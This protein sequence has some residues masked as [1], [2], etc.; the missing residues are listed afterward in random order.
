LS[1]FYGSITY[2]EILIFIY[3]HPVTIYYFNSTLVSLVLGFVFGDLMLPTRSVAL[4]LVALIMICTNVSAQSPRPTAAGVNFTKE[5]TTGDLLT[6]LTI[7]ISLIGAFLGLLIASY[8]DRQLRRKEYADKIRRAAGTIIAKLER[9]KELSLRFYEDIQPLMMDADI[10]LMKKQDVVGTRDYLWRHLVE[11]RATASQRI[12]DEEIE[13]AYADLYGYDSRIHTLYVDSVRRLKKVDAD[14]F[15]RVLE[16]TQSDVLRLEEQPKPFRSAKLGNALRI[17][18]TELSAKLEA[19]LD[20]LVD[21][22]RN[23]MV[24]L[25]EAD[26]KLIVEKRVAF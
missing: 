13:I 10:E 16:R 11:L 7:L 23:Q 6:A 26:D 2:F 21:E 12:V 1:G 8:K 18:C 25:I 19:Q 20:E 17:T 5:I 4:F 14:I 9:W 24:K 15:G 3:Y 22:F